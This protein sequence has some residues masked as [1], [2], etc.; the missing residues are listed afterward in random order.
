MITSK[1]WKQPARRSAEFA[2]ARCV[3]NLHHHS[4]GPGIARAPREQGSGTFPCNLNCYV[5]APSKRFLTPFPCWWCEP[6]CAPFALLGPVCRQ[7]DG[8]ED[9]NQAPS[10][11][12]Q[13]RHRINRDKIRKRLPT[14]FPVP[15]KTTGVNPV[16]RTYVRGFGALPVGEV[17]NI[18]PVPTVLDRE[19][20][21]FS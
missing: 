13:L 3:A 7:G 11:L 18:H 5:T 19:R 14:T 6:T 12:E 4:S 17:W 9:V 2:V 15:Q 16:P 21:V 10:D 20:V 1:E 8:V